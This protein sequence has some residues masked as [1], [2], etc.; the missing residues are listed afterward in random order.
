MVQTRVATSEPVRRSVRHCNPA[1]VCE[2][3]VRAL[4]GGLAGTFAHQNEGSQQ[5]LEDM[6]A[7]SREECRPPLQNFAVTATNS[8]RPKMS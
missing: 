3:V 2:A 5:P 1:S 7:S 4:A 6:L 8:C